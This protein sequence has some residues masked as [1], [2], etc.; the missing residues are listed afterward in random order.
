MATSKARTHWQALKDSKFKTAKPD[1]YKQFSQG[2]GP[3]LDAYETAAFKKIP[4]KSDSN[5]AGALVATEK[6]TVLSILAK[7]KKI[8]DKAGVEKQFPHSFFAS[9]QGLERYLNRFAMAVA[10]GQDANKADQWATWP[11]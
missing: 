1:L 6:A 11:T 10:T 3:A 2:L 4:K 8:V 7:Y 9:G 5:K